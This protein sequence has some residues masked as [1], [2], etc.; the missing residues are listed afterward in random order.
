MN[1]TRKNLHNLLI[2][3]CFSYSY[4]KFPQISIN[5]LDHLHLIHDSFQ[6]FHLHQNIHYIYNCYSSQNLKVILI[7]IFQSFIHFRIFQFF[8]YFKSENEYKNLRFVLSSRKFKLNRL[9]YSFFISVIVYH[10]VILV[11]LLKFV[12]IMLQYDLLSSLKNS[13]LRDRNRL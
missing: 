3:V 1:F 8:Q 12:V 6:Y 5:Y 4:P 11:F 13:K 10:L 9:V 7:F 2:I